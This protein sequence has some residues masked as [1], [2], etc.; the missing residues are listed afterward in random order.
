M[1]E[2]DYIR[3]QF[4]Q[5]R[6]SR[7]IYHDRASVIS[8]IV[9]SNSPSDGMK[10]SSGFPVSS[11]EDSKNQQRPQAFVGILQKFPS[12]PV[13]HQTIQNKKTNTLGK[14]RRKA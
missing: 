5:T 12:P 6:T 4:P 13:E 2:D 7:V 10:F 8:G 9:D 14:Y 11:F 3:D 1:G